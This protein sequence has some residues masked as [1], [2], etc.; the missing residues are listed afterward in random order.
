MPNLIGNI[1]D[2]F[3]ERTEAALTRAGMVHSQDPF[4]R[5]VVRDVQPPNLPAPVNQTLNMPTGSGSLSAR[6]VGNSSNIA[7]EPDVYN[8]AM[9]RMV[10][11]DDFVGEEVFTMLGEIEEI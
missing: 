4:A 11:I 6:N 2:R 3:N 10:S 5:V 9:K 8:Q 7:L 1:A